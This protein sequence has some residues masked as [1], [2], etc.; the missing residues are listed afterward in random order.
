MPPGML[1]ASVGVLGSSPRS[2]LWTPANVHPGEQ[3]LIGDCSSGKF[4][5]THTQRP[6][7]HLCFP[8][9]VDQPW[10]LW[11]FEEW[12]NKWEGCVCVK[13]IFKKNKFLC[14]W[15]TDR[16]SCYYKHQRKYVSWKCFDNRK[17]NSLGGNEKIHEEVTLNRSPTGSHFKKDSKQFKPT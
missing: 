4:P 16:H 5:A 13:Y 2:C 7:L 6:G 11:A 14:V 15:E 8:P 9:W 17:R 12:G 1:T 3:H 10:L